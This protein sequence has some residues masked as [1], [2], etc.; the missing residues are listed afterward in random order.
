MSILKWCPY[1]NERT[2]NISPNQINQF[3]VCVFTLYFM[4][5]YILG[6]FNI[7]NSG[8]NFPQTFLFVSISF[9]SMFFFSYV[10]VPL[11]SPFLLFSLLFRFRSSFF[12][13]WH[14]CHFPVML[15]WLFWASYLE[16]SQCFIWFM[17]VFLSP[18]RIDNLYKW[19][20]N[21]FT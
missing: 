12:L 9:F 3:F 15:F 1:S 20:D 21:S 6:K 10:S 4:V 13:K 7:L 14:P 16:F 19:K 18:I 2:I 17:L 5:Y 8:K 11:P